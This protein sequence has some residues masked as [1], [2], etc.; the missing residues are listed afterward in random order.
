MLHTQWLSR[1]RHHLQTAF[2][3]ISAPLAL[4]PCLRR[5]F[6]R[7]WPPLLDA[8]KLPLRVLLRALQLSGGGVTAVLARHQ[9]LT[10]Q[11]ANIGSFLTTHLGAPAAAAGPE[12]GDSLFL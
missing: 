11:L 3:K 1:V 7:T 10:Q 12:V 5:Q 6:P 9:P 2:S 4:C 8:L